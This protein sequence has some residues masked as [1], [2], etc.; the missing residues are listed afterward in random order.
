[1]SSVAKTI[2]VALVQICETCHHAENNPYSLVPGAPHWGLAPKSMGW[3]GLS[4]AEIAQTLLDP[5]KNGDRSFEDLLHHMSEDPLVLWAWNPDA[6]R[7][8]P[9]IPHDEF[10]KALEAWLDAGAPI[11]AE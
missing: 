4:E 8:P 7:T 11:P 10:V 9:S 2:T 5:T 1:M 6:G 3:L